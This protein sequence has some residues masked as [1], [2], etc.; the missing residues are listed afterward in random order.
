MTARFAADAP[1]VG[2]VANPHRPRGTS[3]NPTAGG[4]SEVNSFLDQGHDSNAAVDIMAKDLASVTHN[5]AGTTR[6]TATGGQVEV[7]GGN[8]AITAQFG[9][10]PGST[11]VIGNLDD[12]P[13]ITLAPAAAR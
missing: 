3:I 12:H 9:S 5:P 13:A 10:G 2:V 6:T 1:R 4:V 8:Y 7:I 11:L